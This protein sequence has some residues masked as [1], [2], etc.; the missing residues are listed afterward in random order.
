MVPQI[1]E[2][3]SEIAD[4]CR[5][6]QVRKLEVFGSAEREAD[7]DPFR[8]GT[9]FLVEFTPS[10]APPP[11]STYFALRD[12]LSVTVGRRI[13]SSPVTSGLS[14]NRGAA[15]A[16]KSHGRK[17]PSHAASRWRRTHGGI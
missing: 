8:S 3:R 13:P 6:L 2:H 5:R 4:L 16:S 14:E 15:V 1:S 12:G 9:D 11:L 10:D 17:R 7:F